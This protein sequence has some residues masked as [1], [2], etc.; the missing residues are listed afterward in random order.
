MT[1]I[2][3]DCYEPKDQQVFMEGMKNWKKPAKKPTAKLSWKARRT[4][5]FPVGSA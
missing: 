4:A 2:V 3:R 5:P 1:V